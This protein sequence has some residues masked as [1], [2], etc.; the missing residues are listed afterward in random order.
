MSLS[1]P[2]PDDYADSGLVTAYSR[3]YVAATAH[4]HTGDRT[5]SVDHL[6]SRDGTV[7]VRVNGTLL[8]ELPPTDWDRLKGTGALL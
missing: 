2:N 4:F 7:S 6:I 3:E 1:E 5:V 8:P